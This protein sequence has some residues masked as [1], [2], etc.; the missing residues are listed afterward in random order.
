MN[1]EPEARD[2]VEWRALREL[3]E[4]R[5][6][7][8]ADDLA[9]LRA[10][11]AH[12]RTLV[13]QM[14]LNRE[15][16][17]RDQTGKELQLQSAL[18]AAQLR[19]EQLAAI[20]HD[21]R[22]ELT[23]AR[24]ERADLLK[25]LDAAREEYF[26]LQRMGAASRARV[27]E[28]EEQLTRLKTKHE[29]EL[30]RLRQAMLGASSIVAQTRG[31]GTTDPGYDAVV[32]TLLD[33]Y[34]V[35]VGKAGVQSYSLNDQDLLLGRIATLARELDETKLNVRRLR[36]ERD[37]LETRLTRIQQA[38][39]EVYK[40]SGV[41]APSVTALMHE[42]EEKERLL[43]EGETRLLEARAAT[44]A[45]EE[46]LEARDREVK[47]LK[48]ALRD[49]ASTLRQVDEVRATVRELIREERSRGGA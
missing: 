12:E 5:E 36:D 22:T 27:T 42:V 49:M 11:L 9:R 26:T 23:E 10:E 3:H 31:G 13:Q 43:C 1:F 33:V 8:L 39:R 24:T 37:L 19:A 44:R 16:E 14:Q 32:S 40:G 28:L 2:G 6:A 34:N 35:N 47:S 38:Q 21:M 15:A 45:A 30:G 7:S 29:E 18:A 41:I 25:R 4:A 48:A 46:R 17:L 20:V